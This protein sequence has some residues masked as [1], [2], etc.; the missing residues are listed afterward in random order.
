MSRHIA[1]VCFRIACLDKA[2]GCP[3]VS[4]VINCLD[5]FNKLYRNQNTNNIV[6]KFITKPYIR[7]RYFGSHTSLWVIVTI[8]HFSLSLLNWLTK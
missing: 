2:P 1:S 7:P 8:L 5:Q 4:I 6:A 3:L